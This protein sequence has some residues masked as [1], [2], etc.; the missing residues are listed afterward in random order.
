MQ[1]RHLISFYLIAA[2]TA[3]ADWRVDAGY[4]KLSAVLG[5]NL[6]TGAG[7]PVLMSE[8]NFATLPALSYLPQATTGTAPF[9]GIGEFAGKTFYPSSGASSASSHATSVAGFFYGNSTSIS[10]GV[11]DVHMWLAD[12]FL[13]TVFDDALNP[14]GAQPTFTGSVMNHS[15][16]GSTQDDAVDVEVTRKLDYLI[17]RDQ[18]TCVTPLNNGPTQQA[19]I[20]NGYHGISV[21]LRSGNHPHTHSSIDVLNRM[22]PDLVVDVSLTSYAGPAV[23]S[24]AA[25]LLDVIRPAYP[26]ADHPRVVKALLLTAASKDRLPAWRRVNTARPYDENFGAGELN[27]YQA[28]RIL[29]AGQF[30]NSNTMV[31]PATGW[32]TRTTGA[33]GNVRRYF[34]DVPEG[35]WAQTFTASLTWH[36]NFSSGVSTAILP[37]LTL[38]LRAA[39]GTTPG[40]QIDESVSTIDNVEHLFLRYLPAGRYV[41]EVSSDTPSI[42]YALA[43]QSLIGTGPSVTLQRNAPASQLN[44]SQLDPYVLYTVQGSNDLTSWTNLGT[45]RTA[46]TVAS[47]TG[48]MTESTELQSRFYRLQW[49]T[50]R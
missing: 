31:R 33:G 6:P 44:F 39:T 48:S 13:Q 3:Y 18:F 2:S 7:I 15:W 45:L 26:N 35:S 1:V 36:R 50:W 38:R 11:T 23:G 46:D 40:A 42:S 29:T 9:A 8:A 16:V 10:P 49:T 21:G 17:D 22:K 28:Y 5:I 27:I 47:F 25:L 37:D 32:D 12:G 20:A 4:N 34:F 30:A 41:L 24:A 14:L 43:W 19:L